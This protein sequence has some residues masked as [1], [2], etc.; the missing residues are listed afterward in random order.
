MAMATRSSSGLPGPADLR[1]LGDKPNQ[2]LSFTFPKRKFD[3]TKAIYRSVQEV[4]MA[5]L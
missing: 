3:E 1:D 5:S 2:S 4:A